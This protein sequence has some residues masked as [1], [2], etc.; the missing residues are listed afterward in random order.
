MRS[1]VRGEFEKE[2]RNVQRTRFRVTRSEHSRNKV[3][4]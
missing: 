1:A 4:I 2:K 3:A